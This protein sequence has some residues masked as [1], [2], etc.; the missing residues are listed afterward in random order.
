M[1]FCSV[2]RPRADILQKG[3]KLSQ[4]GSNALPPTTNLT[5]ACIKCNAVYL[6]QKR[7]SEYTALENACHL[8]AQAKIFFKICISIA[9]PYLTLQRQISLHHG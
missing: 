2:P 5:R 3:E 9:C 4:E 7:S 6:L 1:K 8:E